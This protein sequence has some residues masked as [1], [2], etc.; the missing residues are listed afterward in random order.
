MVTAF[1]VK[2][3]KP[4]PEPYLMGL[5]KAHAKPNET[6]VVENAPMGVEAA[7]AANIFTIA[8][9]TGPLPDQVYPDMENLAKDWKQIIEL[10]KS[11][12]LNEYSK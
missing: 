4:H 11:T 7:V 12:R 10:A 6:F 3:G 5:Q 9:N 8:V 1:D 2:Y